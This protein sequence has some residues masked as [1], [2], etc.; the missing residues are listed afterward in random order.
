MAVTEQQALHAGSA[1]GQ[2]RPWAALRGGQGLAVD[3][4]RDGAGAAGGF[5]SAAAAVST[6]LEVRRLLKE[7]NELLATGLYARDDALIVQI[8]ARVQELIT[9]A[10]KKP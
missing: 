7:R 4:M 1:D 5:G 8:D 2:V 9:G 10:G 3:V 6:V